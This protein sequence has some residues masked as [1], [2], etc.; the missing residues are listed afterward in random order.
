MG[1]ESVWVREISP[2]V[3]VGR[4]G[5]GAREVQWVWWKTMWNSSRKSG[6][7]ARDP[8]IPTMAELLTGTPPMLAKR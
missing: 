5:G 3:E 2:E 4:S 7:R 1:G 8:A 6:M